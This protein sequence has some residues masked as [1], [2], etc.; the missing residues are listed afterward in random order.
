VRDSIF[1][2]YQNWQRAVRTDSWKLIVYHVKGRIT[3][4]LFD[5]KNDPWEI[6]NLID[7]PAQAGRVK[8]LTVL[9]KGWMKETEDPLELPL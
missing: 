3:R 1:C 5:L 6:K 8:E 7:E 9:L 4:Q 2:S